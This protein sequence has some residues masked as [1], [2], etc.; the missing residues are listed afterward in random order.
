MLMQLDM[1]PFIDKIPKHINQVAIQAN[2]SAQFVNLEPL[3]VSLKI[4]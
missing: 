4:L 3:L 2:S 1:H